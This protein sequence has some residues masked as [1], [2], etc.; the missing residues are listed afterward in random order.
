MAVQA[1]ILAGGLLLWWTP[2]LAGFTM[3]WA[4]AGSDVS[5]RELHQRTYAH[6]V[7][8]LP[9]I[10]DRPR[11][12]LEHMILHSLILIGLVLAVVTATAA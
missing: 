3:P 8:V 6:M 2:Y 7:T 12:N 5:W 1:V 11:P 9:R 10:K 4:T